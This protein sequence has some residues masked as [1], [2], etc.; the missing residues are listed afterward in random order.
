LTTTKLEKIKEEFFEREKAMRS[1]LEGAHETNSKLNAANRDLKQQLEN[2]NALYTEHKDKLE[3]AQQTHVVFLQEKNE[4]IQS[5]K[6]Y[7]EDLEAKSQQTEVESHAR[8]EERITIE[9]NLKE[10]AQK[11][12]QDERYLV[13]EREAGIVKKIREWEQNTMTQLAEVIGE[14]QNPTGSLAV[15]QN[16]TFTQMMQEGGSS[17]AAFFATGPLLSSSTEV[18]V[19]SEILRANTELSAQL[20][21]L[22]RLRRTMEDGVQCTEAD[23]RSKI[24]E[25]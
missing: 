19:N 15:T 4:E 25:V 6:R 17:A 10:G 20:R 8:L 18:N 12:L 7:L 21:T 23:Y 11:A 9:R 2:L 14:T 1:Q 16:D 22:M 5:L 24:C 13:N 3:T